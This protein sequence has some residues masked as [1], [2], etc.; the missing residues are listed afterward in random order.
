MS[1]ACSS[2]GGRLAGHNPLEFSFNFDSPNGSRLLRTPLLSSRAKPPVAVMVAAVACKYCSG[3]FRT[4][5]GTP[6][7]DDFVC[8]HCTDKIKS[9]IQAV[10]TQCSA[11]TSSI[12]V[13]TTTEAD[14]RSLHS[15]N[16]SLV[17]SCT[18][19]HNVC[20][21]ERGTQTEGPCDSGFSAERS[22]WHDT[23]GRGS[24]GRQNF[25]PQQHAGHLAHSS[26]HPNEGND[27]YP[28]SKLVFIV[29]SS[30]A[31]RFGRYVRAMLSN[32][33]RCRMLCYSRATLHRIVGNL[34]RYVALGS[35]AVSEKLVVLHMDLN[36]L[37]DT[38][39]NKNI[40]DIWRNLDSQMDILLTLCHKHKIRLTICSIPVVG[41]RGSFNRQNDCRYLNELLTEKI[42]GSAV[43]FLNLD[44]IHGRSGAMSHDGFHYSRHGARLAARPIAQLIAR[45]LDVQVLSP[46][47]TSVMHH[48]SNHTGTSQARSRKKVVA[49]SHFST[50]FDPCPP[51]I[52]ASSSRR[53]EI[54]SRSVAMSQAREQ[55]PSHKGNSLEHPEPL[56]YFR[57]IPPPPLPPPPPVTKLLTPLVRGLPAAYTRIPQTTPPV[58]YQQESP[59]VLLGPSTT[60][61]VPSLQ[62]LS[63][64]RWGTTAPRSPLHSMPPMLN[65]PVLCPQQSNP[66]QV[67]DFLSLLPH[68][69]TIPDVPPVPPLSF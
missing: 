12:G 66:V 4:S 54:N 19:T 10:N 57:L 27:V 52:E 3:L 32:D 5:M 26:V 9:E 22:D 42:K 20:L 18:Q 8:I 21:V 59:Q 16:T 40:H 7:A 46:D 34:R 39:L 35:S 60:S 28:P 58:S 13:Q 56:P 1:R 48:V 2:V 38:S 64:L 15:T 55:S 31:V 69:S 63:S 37:L 49:P 44:Y 51:R 53:G 47:I 33:V 6:S 43:D 36:N 24:S 65:L 68:P 14:A 30:N 17:D 62:P 67:S 25:G 45:F 50:R 61:G 11:G 29:G 41:G 23:C